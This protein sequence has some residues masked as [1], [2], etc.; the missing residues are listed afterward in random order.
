M[1]VE[2]IKSGK[3]TVSQNNVKSLEIKAEEK[4]ID[5]NAIDKKFVKEIISSVRD[6][7]GKGSGRGITVV[8]EIRP[9]LKRIVDD[10]S[11]EGVTVTISY[12]GDRVATMGSEANAKLTRFITGTRH[13][14][15]NSL[16]KL[17]KIT[18]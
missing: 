17:V 7:S 12:K 1:L 8:R 18:I 5:V 3:I 16:S 13:V 14:E 9:L 10:F 6:G 2:T 15:I 4:K 11:E